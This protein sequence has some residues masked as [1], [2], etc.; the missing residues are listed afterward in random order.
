[1]SKKYGKENGANYR[2]V[3]EIMEA[4]NVYYLIA[5]CITLY[6]VSPSGK[7]DLLRVTFLKEKFNDAMAL[8][9]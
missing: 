6:I 2:K 3:N 9:V 4:Y 5:R 7:F 8:V 1:M